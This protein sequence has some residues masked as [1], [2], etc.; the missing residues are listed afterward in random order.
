MASGKQQPSKQKRTNQN[1]QQRSALEAR[2]AAASKPS[3]GSTSSS[4]PRAS[5]GLLGRLRGTA[6]PRAATP[7]PATPRPASPLGGMLANRS[8]QPVGYRAALTGLIAAVAA[9]GVSFVLS[10]PVTQ[11]GD[12]YTRERVVAEWADTA[13]RAAQATDAAQPEAVV[14][15]IEKRTDDPWMPNRDSE[16]LAIAAFPASLAMVLP[17]IAAWF[18]FRAVQQRRGSRVVNRAMYATLFGAVLTFGLLTF[19][20]PTVI[21]VGVAGFQVRKAE[22]TAAMAEAAAA[23]GDD[24]GED[25]IIEAEVVDEVDAGDDD[26]ER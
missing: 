22:T 26:A 18:A 6:T 20:L 5:G 21:A 1:R 3:T 24:D 14:D 4:A 10:T 11:D 12:P 17:V 23:A 16:Q 8:E 13:L 9:V 19:F 7:R 2:K 25:E 15:E